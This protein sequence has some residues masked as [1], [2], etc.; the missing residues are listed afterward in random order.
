M[1]LE[2]I[3]IMEK[4]DVCFVCSSNSVRMITSPFLT[5]YHDILVTIQAKMYHCD[6]CHKEFFTPDQAR[7]VSQRV[8][9]AVRNKLGLLSPERIIEIRKKYNLSQ[10]GLERLLGLGAKVVTRWENDRVLQMKTTDDLLRLMERIPAVVK[11]L[12][13]LRE[14]ESASAPV[15]VS[16]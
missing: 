7:N 4:E 15:P 1:E 3:D 14:R 11:E 10:E 9:A 6:T 12:R 16:R 2:F 13:E 8:K 5:K